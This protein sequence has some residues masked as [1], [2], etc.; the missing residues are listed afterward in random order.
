M[1]K[2]KQQDELASNSGIATNDSYTITTN[3]P[4]TYRSSTTTGTLPIYNGGSGYT[5]TGFTSWNS[6]EIHIGNGKL[7]EE[8]GDLIWVRPNGSKFN[9]TGKEAMFDKLYKKMTPTASSRRTKVRK[10]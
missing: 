8:N 10:P 5:T 3:G 7:I 4:I 6:S 2:R 1:A 9:L